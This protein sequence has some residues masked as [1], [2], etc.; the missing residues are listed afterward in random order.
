M[1]AVHGGKINMGPLPGKFVKITVVFN[2]LT[3]DMGIFTE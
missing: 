3:V 1:F 2:F